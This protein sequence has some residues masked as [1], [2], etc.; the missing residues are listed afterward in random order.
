MPFPKDASAAMT[1]EVHS[2]PV[3]IGVR[4]PSQRHPEIEIQPPFL[5][6][7]HPAS[8]M[9]IDGEDG[10]ELL[11]QLS[12]IPVE[13]G[14]AR[15][16]K[17]G[18]PALMI[19]KR[20]SRGWALIPESA[21]LATDTPDGQAGYIRRSQARRGWTHHAAWMTWRSVAG[22]ASVVTDEPGYHRWLRALVER[23]IIAPADP[24]I[25]ARMLDQARDRLARASG[26]DTKPGS[27]AAKLAARAEEQVKALEAIAGVDAAEPARAKRTKKDRTPSPEPTA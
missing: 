14:V 22:R 3:K 2:E 10:P 23:G 7:H 25:V 20:Q 15:V 13:P 8:W 9:V 6:F 27:M 5:Y 21:A 18:D 24:A 1:G 19:G 16:D 17:H 26:R 12:G 11:P 4:A